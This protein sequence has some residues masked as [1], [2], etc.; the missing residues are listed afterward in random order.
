MLTGFEEKIQPNNDPAKE[1]VFLRTW[2]E[3]KKYF[4]LH[5]TPVAHGPKGQ[6]IYSHTDILKLNA[7]FPEELTLLSK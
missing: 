1:V 5:L 7:Y 2:D 6:P 3:A 4:A